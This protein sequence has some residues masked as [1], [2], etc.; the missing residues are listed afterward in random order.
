M[1]DQ[2]QY[3]DRTEFVCQQI[4]GQWSTICPSAG[5]EYPLI[6]ETEKWGNTKLGVLDA[7]LDT[8]LPGARIVLVK[9]D[10]GAVEKIYFAILEAESRERNIVQSL[11]DLA[12]SIDVG[13]RIA[14]PLG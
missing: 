13:N 14:V 11:R 8:L 3:P 7:V 4:I 12:D 6:T 9:S 2:K 10:T 1:T 5:D